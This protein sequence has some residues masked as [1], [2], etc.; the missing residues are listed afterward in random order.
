MVLFQ[1]RD[2]NNDEIDD[3]MYDDPNDNDDDGAHDDDDVDMLNNDED[4]FN[5]NSSSSN[6]NSNNDD[7]SS[8]SSSSGSRSRSIGSS[9]EDGEITEDNQDNDEKNEREETMYDDHPD[10]DNEFCHHSHHYNSS[11]DNDD[12]NDEADKDEH[13]YHNH[14]GNEDSYDGETEQPRQSF[15]SYFLPSFI[16]HIFGR[17]RK[18][19]VSQSPSRSTSR[20]WDREEEEDQEQERQQQQDGEAYEEENRDGHQERE[21]GKEEFRLIAST[22]YERNYD[23]DDFYHRANTTTNYDASYDNNNPNSDET[24]NSNLDARSYEN[25]TGDSS[26][27]LQRHNS[28]TL[29]STSSTVHTGNPNNTNNEVHYHIYVSESQA[30]RWFSSNG[31]NTIDN[32][33]QEQHDTTRRRGESRKRKRRS[34]WKVITVL[35]IITQCAYWLVRRYDTNN[36]LINKYGPLL[37]VLPPPPYLTWTE[38]SN[39][40]SRLVRKLSKE[41]CILLKHVFRQTITTVSFSRLLNNY[42]NQNEDKN[43]KI[44]SSNLFVFPSDWS[45][46]GIVYAGKTNSRTST[47]TTPISSS[48]LQP[49]VLYGQDVALER[50]RTE[51]NN[52]RGHGPRV[53][54][55]T[56]GKSIGKRALAY[57][58]LNHLRRQEYLDDVN[59]QKYQHDDETTTTMTAL[60][61]CSSSILKKNGTS[62][63]TY[64]D[65]SDSVLRNQYHSGGIAASKSRYCPLLRLTPFDY[66]H[67]NF[68]VTNDD[69]DNDEAFSLSFSS[70]LYQ[71]ILDHVV[72]AGGG[73]SIVLFERVDCASSSSSRGEY[74]YDDSNYDPPKYDDVNNCQQDQGQKPESQ[75]LYDLM[76]EIR[77]SQGQSSSSDVFESTMFVMTSSVGTTTMEKWTRKRLQQQNQL[78]QQQDQNILSLPPAP[79]LTSE[80]E[81]LLRYDIRRYHG[82]GNDRIGGDEKNIGLNNDSDRDDNN[83]NRTGNGDGDDETSHN[84][85]R[86]EKDR[87]ENNDDNIVVDDMGI[88]DWI[89]LPMT[90][91]NRN[92]MKAVLGTIA[93]RTTTIRLDRTPAMPGV[94]ADLDSNLDTMTPPVS[95]LSLSFV[96]SESASNRILDGIEWHQWMHKSSKDVLRIWS[97]DGIRP[98]LRLWNDEILATNIF[99]QPHDDMHHQ[100]LDVIIQH[101]SSL[102]RKQQ[103]KLH[104]HQQRQL[105]LLDYDE[106]TTG[107]FVVHSCM[108]VQ[109]VSSSEEVTMDTNNNNQ[110]MKD[111]FIVS[112]IDHQQ[113]DCRPNDF[114]SDVINRNIDICRF[115][116]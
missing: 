78:Q 12:G 29:V 41:G 104:P 6:S 101:F 100:C 110:E 54:Y 8:K 39:Q 96:L 94:A 87:I 76:K 23:Q 49:V 13:E 48:L 30:T 1:F 26:S 53:V 31:N 19:R 88:N 92:A 47:A 15:A 25:H 60:E 115:Y 80:I 33:E 73:A 50:L 91:L 7:L 11:S 52:H 63:I 112:A 111:V 107:Q 2:D 3:T 79:K 9:K 46:L 22:Q 67:N 42:D 18:R 102:Y 66:Y 44:L 5:Y 38:Y 99:Q 21:E 70:R 95:A 108:E 4:S 59:Y 69:I 89:I 81:S 37:L 75:W 64:N 74:D 71:R 40:Q 116:L 93:S 27:S 72:A 57:L 55:V 86:L 83:Q 105:L 16:K 34:L 51:L 82:S 43:D 36:E 84:N 85:K 24:S 77:S 62:S 32:G 10:W 35:A 56:G 68:D 98:L 14:D 17:R 90:P 97:P 65:D 45:S 113:W 58:I 61:E 20:D 114:N 103:Q 28:R 106:N 109:R